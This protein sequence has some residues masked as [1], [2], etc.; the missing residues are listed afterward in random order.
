ME[1]VNVRVDDRLIHGQVATVWCQATNA[2]R[3]MVVD[4][5]V[6]K[7]AINKEALKLACPQGCKLSILT[8]KKATENL[9]ANKYVGE[10]VFIIVK[11]PRT[12]CEMY[13]GGFRFSHVNIGNMG[14]RTDTRM[15][16]KA[17]SVSEEDIRNFLY[18]VD[19]QIKVTAQMVPSDELVDFVSLVK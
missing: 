11:N 3:I 13:D 16:Q 17:V 10:R 6:V 19:Q 8:A 2:S 14:G 5:I 7:D 9:V 12:L 4:N 15:L 1:I 18:L